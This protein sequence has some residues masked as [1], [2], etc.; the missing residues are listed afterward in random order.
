MTNGPTGID[1]LDE[2]AWRGLMHQCTDETGLREHLAG[3]SRRCYTGFDPTSTSLTI[4]NL[5]PLM[6][7]SHWKRAGNEVVVVMGGGTGLIGDPSGKSAE[8]QLLT[9]ERVAEHVAGQRPIFDAVLGSVDGPEHTIVNNAEWLGGLGYLEVLRDVGKHFRV[10]EMVKRDSVRDRLE[11]EQG[12]SYT[13][14]SYMVLQAY[15]FLHLNKQRGVTVQLGGSDQYGNILSG[16]D[17]IRRWA[18][19]A[20]PRPEIVEA[21]EKAREAAERQGRLEQTEAAMLALKGAV[22][23]ARDRQ[24][25]GAFGLTNPLVTKAD[26]T[27]FGKTESGAIWLTADK[28][29]PYAYYQFWLNTPDADVGGFLRFFT[30]LSKGEIEAIEATHAEAP[31]K[32]EAQRTL[33]REATTILHGRLAME[34]AEAAGKALFSGDVGSL[35]EST[36]REVLSEVPSSDHPKPSL[37]GQGIDPVEILVEIGLAESKR[38]ARE[39]VAAG[40]V[41]VNG[42]K[43]GEGERLGSATLLFGSLIAIRRGKKNWHLTRW[44]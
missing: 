4:G 42:R 37:D 17:L 32:R 13:E 8:R 21:A 14:F 3:G 27:K 19:F 18:P 25:S 10:N 7:L 40:S 20:P 41:L 43:L 38:K 33:A 29:S 31:G 36:L 34:Q 15:D 28:T 16:I 22:D 30:F 2:I 6:V 35:D 9:S 26:G 5:V 44:G 24:P 1:F 11:R 39:F 12:I 23:A